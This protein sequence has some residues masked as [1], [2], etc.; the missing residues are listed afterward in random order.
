M[1]KHPRLEEVFLQL[2]MWVWRRVVGTLVTAQFGDSQW[3]SNSP[4]KTNVRKKEDE[5]CRRV[6]QTQGRGGVVWIFFY[7]LVYSKCPGFL[8]CPKSPRSNGAEKEEA[9]LLQFLGFL[10]PA[11]GISATLFSFPLKSYRSFFLILLFFCARLHFRSEREKK[12]GNS[13][14]GLRLRRRRLR[15]AI[16]LR[17]LL[18]L[19]SH[20]FAAEGENSK[21]PPPKRQ[22]CHWDAVVEKKIEENSTT[23]LWGEKKRIL[24]SPN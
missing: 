12:G 15:K 11:E 19:F 18:I 9:G 1:N 8:G 17:L 3:D 2:W 24:L 21:K 13:R 20:I 22:K 5:E 14:L 10:W 23:M 4:R 16:K 7:R 6:R